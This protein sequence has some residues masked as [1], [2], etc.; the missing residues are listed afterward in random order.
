M[1]SEK[2][3]PKGMLFFN[4]L[5]IVG[6]TLF[7][8]FNFIGMMFFFDGTIGT[9][10]LITL[11]LTLLL[12][13]LLIL[14]CVAK[15]K[16]NNFTLW[17]T[18]EFSALALFIIAAG[19]SFFGPIRSLCIM[20]AKGE[21]QAAARADRAAIDTLIAKYEANETNAITNTIIGL[22]NSLNRTLSED[23]R[24]WCDSAKLLDGKGYVYNE[25]IT[26]FKKNQQEVLLGTQFTNIKTN[27]ETLLDQHIGI[28]ESWNIFQ[29]PAQP[30]ALTQ[31]A[32]EKAKQLTELSGNADL[33]IIV[34]DSES[35]SPK[36][37]KDNQ[38]F[39]YDAPS[40]KVAQ[41]ISKVGYGK[42]YA[43]LILIIIHL[44]TLCSYFWTL[45]SRKTL[46]KEK[47]ITNGSTIL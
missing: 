17:R 14:M 3:E 11:G 12:G 4:F 21:I 5:S 36:I 6:I 8:V 22:K 32:E 35:D 10:L 27:T 40:M 24:V 19:A 1:S 44:L 30:A 2:N 43:W 16:D 7:A 26:N 18:V 9:S 39:T 23:L 47:A 20:G 31:L 41:A 13:A 29:M 34:N 42:W 25:Y 38:T 46:I 15:A 37:E 33:P 45:R 28:I